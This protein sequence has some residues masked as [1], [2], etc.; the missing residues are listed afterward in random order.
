MVEEH[1][2]TEAQKAAAERVK[3]A[4]A[5]FVMA[6]YSATLCG[7]T[8]ILRVN[9]QPDIDMREFLERSTLSCTITEKL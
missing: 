2:A 4:W 3:Q 5:E 6:E 9:L 1:M 8:T 7:V